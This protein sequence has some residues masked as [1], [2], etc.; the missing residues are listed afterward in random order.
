MR[1]AANDVSDRASRY[2]LRWQSLVNRRPVHSERVV[3]SN[4]FLSKNTR[5]NHTFVEIRRKLAAAC[6]G[7]ECCVYCES[8]SFERI[9]HVLPRSVFPES[10]FIYKNYIPCCAICNEL[11]SSKCAE[12]VGGGWAAIHRRDGDGIL[13]DE[14][15]SAF[16]SPWDHDIYSLITVDIV[17][18]FLLIPVP[19]LEQVDAVK[20]RCI[21][22][23][24]DF[25]ER[26]ILVRRR[27]AAYQRFLSLVADYLS[28]G[29]TLRQGRIV[30]AIDRS[31]HQLV[32]HVMKQRCRDLS[33]LNEVGSFIDRVSGLA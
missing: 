28:T 7:Y 9:D 18:T 12:V 14:F 11:K 8:S 30:D 25:D 19:G 29:D 21:L 31:D 22:D 10:T 15:V 1:F 23:F 27:R 13:V 33:A 5:K 17:D 24:L 4:L 6:P 32:W 26:D 20:A 16:A 3:A 2:L